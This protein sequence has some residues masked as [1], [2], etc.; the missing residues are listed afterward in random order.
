MQ[1]AVIG[2]SF[3]EKGYDG[4]DYDGLCTM[5]RTVKDVRVSF[6]EVAKKFLK[7]QLTN[8]KQA[9]LQAIKQ[10]NM[11]AEDQIVCITYNKKRYVS[12]IIRKCLSSK[13]KNK[14]RRFVHDFIDCRRRRL[15][16]NRKTQ[17]YLVD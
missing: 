15:E 5:E 11:Y 3:F 9:N 6:P 4:M 7:H 14:F 16:R 1:T 10:S 13:K 12:C 2:D 17:R 8:H